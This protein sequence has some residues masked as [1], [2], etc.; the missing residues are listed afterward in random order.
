MFRTLSDHPLV[1]SNYEELQEVFHQASPVDDVVGERIPRPPS[2]DEIQTIQSLIYRAAHNREIVKDTPLLRH[3]PLGLFRRKVSWIYKRSPIRVVEKTP[4]NCLRV[5]FLAHAFPDARFIFLVRSPEAV[6]SS[7]MEGWKFW[8]GAT[9]GEWTFTK[10]H[11]L[12]PPGWKSYTDK[13]LEEI[14]AFQWIESNR[15]ALR[16]LD[17][18]AADR[19]MLVRHE[20]AVSNPKATYADILDFCELPA[21]PYLAK[22]IASL[23]ERLYTHHGSAPQREKWR[24][25]HEEEVESVRP[26]FQPMKD[27]LYGP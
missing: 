8:S 5:P 10:W 9:D 19:Y 25:L 23:D 24:R 15:I 2:P 21:S 20:N 13:P 27:R 26:L 7:L 18:H 4:A 12:A 16:D 22:R 17:G 11:Y 1:W 14:C 3:L 6:I